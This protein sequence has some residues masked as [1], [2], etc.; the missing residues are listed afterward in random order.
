MVYSLK[1]NMCVYLRAKFEISRIIL[2]RFRQ[3]GKG[4]GKF[5]PPTHTSEQTPGK[6][7]QG[8]VNLS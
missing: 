7:T 6:P 8:R 2:M 1:L 3:G 5:T 4:G